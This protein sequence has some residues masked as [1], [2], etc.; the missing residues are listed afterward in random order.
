MKCACLRGRSHGLGKN[1]A[2]NAETLN[3]I[4][5]LSALS[6]GKDSVTPTVKFAKLG[7]VS[8]ASN[9]SV[10]ELPLPR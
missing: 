8:F 3:V 7:R 5:E 4:V 2:S 1:N 6:A 10:V 9:P